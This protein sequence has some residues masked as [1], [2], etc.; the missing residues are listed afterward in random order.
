M[1]DKLKPDPQFLEDF[2]GWVFKQNY[3]SEYEQASIIM[4]RDF[5]NTRPAPTPERLVEANKT[6]AR[7]VVSR[8]DIEKVLYQWCHDFKSRDTCRTIATAIHHLLEGKKG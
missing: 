1:K 3:L 8:E 6:I 2:K 4:L 5:L 7:P